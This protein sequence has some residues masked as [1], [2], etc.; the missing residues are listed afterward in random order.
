MNIFK[1]W[2]K[3]KEKS[4]RSIDKFQMNLLMNQKTLKGHEEIL[5][6]AEYGLANSIKH[7][8]AEAYA[9][10]DD[11]LVLQ[12][13]RLKIKTETEFK[14][15]LLGKS[16]VRILVHIPSANHS[17]AHYSIFTNFA[18][19]CT[20]LGIENKILDWN[21]DISSILSEF[22]PNV[23]ISSDY[24][25]YIEKID[26]NAIE[27]YRRSN[28]LHIGLT[29]ALEEYG[30]TSLE[31]RLIWAKQN[32]IDFYFSFRD[33]N[34]IRDKRGYEQFF[35]NGYPMLFLPFGV[36]IQHY[37][38][39]AGYK[40]DIDY[41]II[42]TRKS[43]HATYIKYITNRHFGFIDGPGW[44]HTINFNFNR[45]RDRY[46]YA[47]TKVA[48]NVHQSEQ[49][50]DASEINERTHQLA[51][52]GVPQLCDHPKII[53]KFYDP[54]AILIANDPREYTEK[55]AFLLKNREIATAMALRAQLRA[56]NEHTTF[57]RVA[58]FMEQL[59][60]HYFKIEKS[61]FV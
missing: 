61:Y 4:R 6:D 59:E 32:N 14:D 10:S 50:R 53:G 60:S 11:P 49:I 24:S 47:R 36:S 23:L 17:P 5:K 9:T 40:R 33:E 20:F 29:A 26:W 58:S 38:P 55:F 12:G 41:S 8:S 45:D 13:W 42:A 37:Y 46:I 34:Y 44:R 43:E 35:K 30:N 21:E 31:K 22:K 56:F 7:E 19:S 27:R 3:R 52:C 2:Q 18:D 28:E 39:V 51:A 15:L 1:A 57:H 54:D 16:K 25:S 48:L